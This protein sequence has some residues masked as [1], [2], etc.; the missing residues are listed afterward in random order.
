MIKSKL[1]LSA[2]LILLLSFFKI[3][4]A[5]AQMV[6]PNSYIQGTSLEI[7][8]EG[9]GGFEGVSTTTSP[10]PAG[11][12]YR[13]TSNLFGFYANPQLNA[14]AG[15]AYDGD[16]FTPGSPENG[17]GFEI[18]TTGGIKK[19]NNCTGLHEIPGA[20]TSWSHNFNC[21]N[22]DWEGDFTSGTDLHFKINYFLQQTD[23]YYT[24]TVSITNN[25]SATIPDMYYYRNVDPDNNQV[26]SGSFTTTNT[27]VS[28]PGSGC[29]LAH[30]KATQSTP[31][32]SYLGFA[33]TGANWR[34]DYGGFGNRDA[35]DLFTGTG[36]TQT[37]GSVNVADEA[38]ALAYHII[39]L[40]P[41][42]TETFKFV[43]I[44]DDASATAAVNNLLYLSYPGSLT[45]PPAVCTPYSDTV[46][47]CGGPVPI[48]I[49]GPIVSNYTW[50][51]SPSTGLTPPTG[52]SVVANP[53]VTTTYTAIG[54]PISA[55]LTPIT[56]PFVVQ[57]TP[58]SGTNPVITP[59]GPVC[60]STPAFNLT[61][62]STGGTW[63][64]PGITNTTLGTFDP[65]AAGPGTHLITYYT[66]AWCNS[67]DTMNITVLGSASA[68]IVQPA[69]VCAG[70]AAF[71]LT[72]GATGGTW[73]GTGITSASAGTFNPTTAGSFIVNYAIAGTCPSSDTVVVTVNP[74]LNATIT[75]PGP[76]CVTAAPIT[77]TAVDPGGVWSGTGI[78]SA[79][80]G[81]FNPTTAGV[82]THII[83]YTISGPCPSVDT[84]NIN[85]S[86]IYNATITNVNPVC[87]SAASFNM[88]AA[89]PGGSWTGTGIINAASGTFDPATAG[90]GVHTI[91]Y[92]ISGLCGSVDTTVVTVIALPVISI[93]AD[94]T[95]GCEPTTI[96][97]TSTADQPGGTNA[98]DFGVL[99]S[100]SDTSIL[101]N[102]SYQYQSAGIYTVTYTY[103]NTI[104]CVS[105]SVNT[106]LI[107]IH[108]L[109]VAAFVALPQPVDVLNPTINFIDQSVGSVNAWVW[110]F[111]TGAGSI[112][113]NPSYDYPGVGVF[114]VQ[115]AV[116][117]IY[118][119]VDT[120]SD[121]VTVDPVY[122]YYAPN[123][124]TP[125][126]DG[127]NDVFMIKG[128]NI[129][130]NKF[131]MSVFDRWGECIF[132]TNDLNIGWNGAKHNTGA[133]VQEDVYVYKVDL[134]D[135]QGIRH[136]YIGH[137][138]I[139]K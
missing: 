49:S 33:A 22:S 11:Y 55:C 90:A 114:P 87:I 75:Q 132:K 105:T 82:G 1:V 120:V 78:T 66:S 9:L 104:G 50:T 81:T 67:T 10:P 126:G 129:D 4:F 135:W 24:T 109:P 71:N 84:V 116:M 89:T 5:S 131:E 63:M 45:A 36:F 70:S 29:D 44:L 56:I 59:V 100:S 136:Q 124:F 123:A 92:T 54:T 119:C 113:Q 99:T 19:S 125:N 51:W 13:G 73:S 17:W 65:L 77:L 37:V 79:T 72:A 111:G 88:T 26:L 41:G 47:T 110:S 137:V 8:V 14:W 61:V 3:N 139:V 128:D 108:A 20:I 35:S 86:S 23:L 106:N 127:K 98:W 27:I 130:P 6:G 39:N 134:R 102:P 117:N 112:I 38:I 15:S 52:P 57:V 60:E 58:A 31:W 62:D 69:A 91:T 34:A 32:N 16:F 53:A 118:G 101:A 93:V 40:A 18:G 2:V 97:F 30:V 46:R 80:L 68:T 96:T 21:Y 103:T 76:I 121:F 122:L 138:T 25:T 133:L 107:T 12:H 95:Q 64:G 94:T 28:Q 115:L 7:G 85:V 48:T 43:V 42:A 74:T 83:M